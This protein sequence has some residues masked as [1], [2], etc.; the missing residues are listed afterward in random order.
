[1][2]HLRGLLG[3]WREGCPLFSAAASSETILNTSVRLLTVVIRVPIIRK[4]LQDVVELSA[5]L[6]ASPSV[7]EWLDILLERELGSTSP[8]GSHEVD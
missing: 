4:K 3:Y 7:S 1:M 8:E 2:L 5:C 6:W